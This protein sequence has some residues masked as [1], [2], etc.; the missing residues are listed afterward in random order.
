MS[1]SP[2]GVPDVSLGRKECS[3]SPGDEVILV[4][5]GTRD[6]FCYMLLRNSIPTRSFQE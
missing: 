6:P 3:H 4:L 2:D 5:A 1:G